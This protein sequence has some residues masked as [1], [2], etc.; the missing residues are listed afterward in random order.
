MRAF[1]IDP[2]DRTICEIDFAGGLDNFYE[3]L[4]CSCITVAGPLP[5]GDDVW[6][7]DEGLLKDPEYFFTIPRYPT[8]LAGRG[9]V[10]SCDDQ[11]AS[12]PA[13]AT[14]TDLRAWIGF[15]QLIR[16]PRSN[17]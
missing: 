5:N 16:I 11:G 13:N 2:E 10:L 12:G 4:G 17:P 15:Q 3:V 7:D 14:L 1:L 9:L 8:P 6:V